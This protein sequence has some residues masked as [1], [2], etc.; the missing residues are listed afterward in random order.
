[1]KSKDN[2]TLLEN[3]FSLSVLQ[4]VNIILPLI[5]LPYL[6]R[7]LGAENYGKV[8]LAASTV[9]Y[10][11]SLTDYSFK[12]TA[13]RDVAI[14][15]GSNRKLNYIYSKVMTI[16]SLIAVFS[17]IILAITVYSY[18]PFYE[19]RLTFFLTFPML[20]GHV[21]F[22]D[23]FF[24]GLEK[25]K[26]ITLLNVGVKLFFTI[27]IFVFI[28]SQTDYWIYPLLMSS[29]YVISGLISQIILFRNYKLKFAFLNLRLIQNTLKDNFAI[30]INQFL[31]NLYNNTT[32]F[33]LGILI[34]PSAVGIYDAIKKIVDLCITIIG[35]FSR[36]SFPFLNRNFRFF[37][38]YKKVTLISSVGLA[39]IVISLHPFIF[40]YLHISYPN[41]LYV[42]IFLAI[43]IVG[44]GLYDIYGT[45]YFL[46]KREDNLVMM[47]TI[48]ASTVGFIL[49]FPLIYKFEIIGAAINLMVARLLMGSYLFVK[50]KNYEKDN[51]V[52]ECWKE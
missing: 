17:L 26:Y 8:I 3:F 25:M 32:T 46:I 6:L 47:S 18:P 38:K 29:G 48:I 16:K 19:E 12:I 11:H 51:K 24:Q 40:W 31:P 43:G 20:L 45:N 42:L 5:T 37:S 27:G 36:V 13:T 30:F 33:L 28:R 22:P 34:G 7:I 35:I 15:R 52:L 39:A 21:L 4:A 14:F 23:W 44:Y 1:L 49:A 2:R 10:F 9:L 41:A 50:A